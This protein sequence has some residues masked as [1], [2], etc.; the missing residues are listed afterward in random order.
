MNIKQL[1]MIKCGKE[2]VSWQILLNKAP[3]RG[4]GRNKEREPKSE[5]KE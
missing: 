5:P 4:K 3:R 2:N 1:P